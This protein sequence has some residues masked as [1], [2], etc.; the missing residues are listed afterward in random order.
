MP[1]ILTETILCELVRALQTHSK[2]ALDDEAC[3]EIIASSF[4]LSDP[5]A[6]L[7]AVS[8]AE[9]VAEPA[10]EG[11]QSAV[12]TFWQSGLLNSFITDYSSRRQ[13]VVLVLSGRDSIIVLSSQP[14]NIYEIAENQGRISLLS[15][16][17]G[18]WPKPPFDLLGQFD[19][20][21]NA[22]DELC[23]RN[24]WEWAHSSSDDVC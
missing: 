15:L 10:Q 1:L 8:E 6:L 19:T 20:A 14:Q 2:G 4:S 24:G 21:A 7:S 9:P 16:G 22:F 13:P 11:N 23:L 18:P 5:L 12:S 17:M 3:L